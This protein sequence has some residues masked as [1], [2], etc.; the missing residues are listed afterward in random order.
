[1][2]DKIPT[3][4]RTLPQ[5]GLGPL[6]WGLALSTALC[7]PVAAA[8]DAA[9]AAAQD[10]AEPAA[11]GKKPEK[12]E[13]TLEKVEVKTRL[14]DEAR[15]QSTASKIVISR[16]EVQKYGDSNVSEVLKRLPGVTV[17]GRPGRGGG[18]RMRGMGAGYTQI[19]VNGEPLPAGFP[20]E[21][22]TPDQI[23]RIE[24]ARAPTAETGARAIA[25]SINIV[26]REALQ[27]RLNEF[28]PGLNT[29]NDQWQSTLAW[30]RNDS[31]GTPDEEG[32]R[33]PGTYNVSIQGFHRNTLDQSTT[34]TQA[35]A[36]DGSWRLNQEQVQSARNLAEGL[37]ASLRLQYRVDAANQWTGQAF[38]MTGRN[39]G[40]T[41]ATLDPRN[42]TEP[43]PWLKSNANRDSD[44]SVLRLNTQWNWKASDS[45]RWEWKAGTGGFRA[46]GSQ[47]T[48]YDHGGTLA[49]EGSTE[50]TNSS[51]QVKWH[52][53][54]DKG[55]AWVTGLEWEHND[56]T[57]DYRTWRDG[58]PLP[59]VSEGSLSATVQ[60]IAVYTQDEWAIN[61][62]WS[63]YAGL[64]WESIT[65]QSQD[66]SWSG[67]NHRNDVA[68][69]LFHVLWRPDPAKKDQIRLSLTRSY[70]SPPLTSLIARPA[71]AMDYPLTGPNVETQPDRIGNPQLQ[72]ELAS[73]LDLSFERYLEGGGML[74]ATV[75]HRRITGLIR[76]LTEL[77]TVSWSPVPRWVSQARNVG[78]AI[79]QGLELEAKG[80]LNEFWTEAPAI[81]VRSNLA[82]YRSKVSSVSGPDNRIDEQAPM[83]GN[84]GADYRFKAWPLQVGGNINF[85]PAHTIRRSDQQSIRT[86]NKT[87]GE[88]FAAWTFSPALTAR[89]NLNPLWASEYESLNRTGDVSAWTRQDVPMALGIRLE[90]KL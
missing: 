3:D 76:N 11:S 37:N 10:K 70:R 15:R 88:L 1:M 41:T 45:S 28:R 14:D 2:S 58:L 47:R 82:L 39:S 23:E 77:Q 18:P 31:F 62:K 59:G 66:R 61:P 89:L 87:Q 84:I 74:S 49:T 4:T 69:P 20:L 52:L 22:L 53:D 57:E 86:G 17:G 9:T 13:T 16:E 79:S 56:R 19:L 83:T 42:G 75:F 72:P 40:E 26:L 5:Q 24:V 6:A 30:T 55:H 65:T 63:A 85:V 33:K 21:S 46:N 32:E 54:R 12:P 81:S 43:A 78:D 68:T 51:A 36:S 8:A 38:A 50:E 29:E 27:R 71:Y 44:F 25:G 90:W 7:A 35:L 67:I 80:R 73:G 34:L 64:R 60:R 48:L